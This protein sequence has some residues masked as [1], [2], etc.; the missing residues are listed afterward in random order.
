MKQ[1]DRATLQLQ[2][3]IVASRVLHN[4]LYGFK[5]EQFLSSTS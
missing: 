4:I 3:S 1:L 2:G 5:L